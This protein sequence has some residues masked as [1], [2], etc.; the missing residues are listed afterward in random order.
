MNPK[1]T[2][3]VFSFLMAI[4]PVMPQQPF[5]ADLENPKIFNQNKEKPH[6]TFLPFKNAQQVITND[7]S[8][9]PYYKLLNGTWKFRWVKNPADRPGD[10]YKPGYDASGWD[11]IVVPSNWELQG[12]GIPIY[13]NQPYEFADKRFPI[14]EMKNGPE[15][16]RVP[17]DYNPVGSYRRTFILPENWKG[18]QVFIHFTLLRQNQTEPSNRLSKCNR[19]CG[20]A[21]T[22]WR[23]K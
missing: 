16:P 14:T 21:C 2:C 18:R 3:V 15:P 5:P 7:W 1:I 23:E 19:I 6:A 13:V 17:H 4:L 12:Y 10:F 8:Q 20:R 22:F 9:S 11:D